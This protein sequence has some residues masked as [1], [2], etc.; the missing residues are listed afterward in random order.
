MET[1]EAPVT[2]IGS[3]DIVNV[4]NINM[5]SDETA[6]P[7]PPK[8]NK[9][10]EK[11]P[12]HDCVVCDPKGDCKHTLPITVPIK[13]MTVGK[14]GYEDLFKKVQNIV[15]TLNEA[16]LEVSKKSSS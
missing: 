9:P 8:D 6:P 7:K 15:E 5:T 3:N 14:T 10:K 13:I 4:E 16:G 11:K 12:T 2:E 1:P